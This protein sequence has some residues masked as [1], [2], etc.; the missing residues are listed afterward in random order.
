MA[1]ADSSIVF[2]RELLT[3][4]LWD[5][6]LPLV[7]DHWKEVAHYRD[8]PLNP[9]RD[10]YERMQAN[11]ALRTF[12]ARIDGHLVGYAVLIL[13][14]AL[15]YAGCKTA[16]QDVVFVSPSVRKTGVGIRFLRY[17]ERE[18]RTEGCQVL[19][20]HAKHRPEL[21]LGA[22]LERMGYEAVDVIYAKRLDRVQ[23]IVGPKADAAEPHD[24]LHVELHA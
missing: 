18:C 2:A 19:Y 6:A 10:L 5:E 16:V 22:V 24:T 12:T 4:A 15:H 20:H 11:G 14:F 1:S 21:A 7:V 13:D 8:I 17:L 9:R 23:M 3:G